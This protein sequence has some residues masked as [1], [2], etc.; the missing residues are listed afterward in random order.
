MR[1]VYLH[2]RHSLFGSEVAKVSV[3][4]MIVIFEAV[5]KDPIH[6]DVVDQR[7]ELC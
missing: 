1:G 7:A 5:T 4:E 3:F 2:I 6:A